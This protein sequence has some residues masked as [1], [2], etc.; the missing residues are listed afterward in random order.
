[1][2]AAEVDAAERR[3]LGAADCG[4]KAYRVLPGHS[5]EVGGC[6]VGRDRDGRFSYGHLHRGR[7]ADRHV[8]VSVE[9]HRLTPPWG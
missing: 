2:A 9:P 6:S 8:N 4:R 7:L 3:D 5:G 1:M